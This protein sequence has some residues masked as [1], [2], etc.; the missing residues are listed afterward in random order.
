MRLWLARCFKHVC[1]CCGGDG[2][3]HGLSAP[4]LSPSQGTQSYC[5]RQSTVQSL[6]L[7]PWDIGED[8]SGVHI[9]LD[10]IL[11]MLEVA[12]LTHSIVVVA[13][14]KLLPNAGFRFADLEKLLHVCRPV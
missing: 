5:E 14:W 6:N 12:L 1:T 4:S 2:E 7:A 3:M 13:V 8:S 9:F 10:K 11:D